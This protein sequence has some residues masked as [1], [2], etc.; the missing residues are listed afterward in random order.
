[1]NRRHFSR[2][3][4]LGASGL[5]ASAL[6]A[7]CTDPATA[8]PN[9]VR[10][11][12]H[13]SDDVAR[14]SFAAM[15]SSWKGGE[16]DINT[17][18]HETFKEGINNYLQGN[19]DDVFTW[20]AGYRARYFSDRKLVADL[21]DVWDTITGMPESMKAASTDDHGRQ[22][23]IPNSYYPWAIFYKPSVFKEHGWSIPTTFDDWITL[24]D[25]IKK[26]GMDPIAMSDKDG[27]E[28]M[29]TFDQ[30]N[31]RVNG[32]D[33]H[34]DLMAGKES[35]KS[36][37]VKNVFAAWKELLP[38]HQGDPLGRTWQEAAQSV[39]NEKSAMY[40]MGMFIE[41]QWATSSTPDD[42]DFFV[43]PEF[44]SAIGADVVEAP[45]DGFMLAA[46]PHNEKK[47]K[48]LLTYLASAEAI[49]Y[50]LDADPS[51]I[52]PRSDQDQSKYSPLQKKAV[53]LVENASNLSQFMDRDTRPD[54]ASTV[55]TPALQSF[56]QS[57]DSLDSI[58]DS[59]EEQKQSIFR[60]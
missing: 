45:V 60:A 21:S 22:I 18:D 54:F 35:W 13:Q 30:L 39:L 50:K 17:V 16:P 25:A 33:F 58:L 24:N 1:M 23:F 57:P 15:I 9:R 20:F 2:R 10:V 14:S 19:P 4:F 46:R 56:L 47:A 38:Y 36:T 43:V 6:L 42:L 40:L 59:V 32:Y 53:E 37:E 12:S 44:D 29:G 5:G 34:V 52:S 28:A 41:Q 8:N 3:S 49:Q 11:G 26:E 48:E 27:W 55:M 7:S 51:V 31:L